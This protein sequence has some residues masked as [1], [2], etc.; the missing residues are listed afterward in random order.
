M[1]HVYRVNERKEILQLQH[2][3]IQCAN[4]SQVN[5]CRD[6]AIYIFSELFFSFHYFFF[7]QKALL[8]IEQAFKSKWM[9]SIKIC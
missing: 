2:I 1:I 8:N 4:N 6:S 5:D 3:H 7:A 9:L